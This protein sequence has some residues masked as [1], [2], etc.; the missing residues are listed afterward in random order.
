MI[1]KFQLALLILIAILWIN[2]YL[3]Y[4]SIKSLTN[5]NNNNFSSKP[6]ISILVPA[7][8][9]ARNIGNCVISLLAQDYD[10]IEIIVLDD[11]S[12][13]ETADIIKT[14]I[15]KEI[16]NKAGNNRLNLIKGQPLPAGWV[17]KCWACHQL[18]AY[19]QGEWLLFT[20][21][22][23]KF[24]PQAVSTA[25][26]FALNKKADLLSILPRQ[27]ADNGA[28][29]LIMPLLYFILYTLLPG[30]L[31]ERVNE[32]SISAAIGQF[33]LFRK[34][35][36]QTIK[37][38]QGV[39]NS[40]IE[41]LDLA[42]NIKRTHQRL[43]LADG[44]KLIQCRMYE[45]LN[46][47]IKGFTKNF[48]A[49]FSFSIIKL[50]AFMIFN[51]LVYILPWILLIINFITHQFNNTILLVTILLPFIL[52]LNLARRH[53]SNLWAI[54]LHPIA[55]LIMI[56]IAGNSIIK[57]ITGHGVEWKGRSY[58]QL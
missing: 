35:A 40:I 32:A 23:T 13:D 17:G 33:L 5:A 31:L 44:N 1:I 54:L 8:N 18:S 53:P 30:A 27:L 6:L 49:S 3:N 57:I 42:K 37:G 24:A 22:D 45:D 29:K 38:H 4:F 19:A 25:L 11:E 20:D 55:T 28:V 9:E 41:D 36:Y 10:H 15:D 26:A 58:N 52:R 12:S 43:V 39:F 16:I 50:G 14:L 46:E 47:L 48:F 21:A 7:R 34:T 2:F 56:G 51:L